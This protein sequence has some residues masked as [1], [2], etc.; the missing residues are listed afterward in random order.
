MSWGEKPQELADC[1]DKARAS[2]EQAPKMVPIWG[3]RF[4]PD[5][6]NES[7]NPVFSIF[8]TDIIHYA[9][10]LS[11]YFENEFHKSH[12]APLVRTAPIKDIP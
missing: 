5:R 4:I 9:A 10:N 12:E 11:E 3:H 2:L 1:F 6:P 8:Q 7:G